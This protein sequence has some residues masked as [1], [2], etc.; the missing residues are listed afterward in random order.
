MKN[1]NHDQDTTQDV[2]PIIEI[3]DPYEFVSSN[4]TI[5]RLIIKGRRGRQ[6]RSL[7]RTKKGGYMT[8]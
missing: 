7:I 5:A 3:V 8:Q 2:I 4:K 6:N 1:E